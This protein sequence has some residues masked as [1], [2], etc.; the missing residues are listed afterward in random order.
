MLARLDFTVLEADPEQQG[1]KLCLQ[2][3]RTD[4]MRRPRG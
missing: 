3:L 1:L 4:I 2:G